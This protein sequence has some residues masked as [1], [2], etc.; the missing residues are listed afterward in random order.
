M[1]NTAPVRI[2]F[3]CTRNSARSQM[4]EAITRHLGDGKV[5]VFSAGTEATDVHPMARRAMDELGVGM[6]GQRSKHLKEFL[7]QQ[8]D[9]VITVCDNAHEACPRFPGNPEQ[10]HWSFP[11]P[12]AIQGE[13]AQH[14]AFQATAEGLM[15]RIRTLLYA[16]DRKQKEAS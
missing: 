9:Y 4:A 16:L 5:E 11:D 3:L 2:L 7:G 12:A 15:D 1:T 10:I 8:F 6:A 13:E 14:D